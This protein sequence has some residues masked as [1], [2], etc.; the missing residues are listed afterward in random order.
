MSLVHVIKQDA[1]DTATIRRKLEDCGVVACSRGDRVLLKPNM[2]GA[3]RPEKAVTTHPAVVEAVAGI[4]VDSGAEVILGDSPGAVSME[5]AMA[6]CGYEPLVKHMGLQTL[7][8]SRTVTVAGTHFRDIRLA[9]QAL[10]CDCIVNLPKVKTHGQML[11]TLALKNL[12]GLV[13]GLGKAHWHLRTGGDQA[14]FA[15][16]LADIAHTVLSRVRSV[17]VADGV[18]SMEGRGPSSGRPRQ[19]S[20]LAVSGSALALDTAVCSLLGFP[21]G[22]LPVLEPAGRLFPEEEHSVELRF[23]GFDREPTLPVVGN[24]RFIE[25]ESLGRPLLFPPFLWR[26][27]RSWWVPM[28]KVARDK[29]VSCRQCARICAA[30]AISFAGEVPYP[31]FDQAKC[32]RCYCCEEICPENAITVVRPLFRRL[33]QPGRPKSVP[34]ADE[35]NAGENGQA[36]Q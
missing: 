13:P 24:F 2:L 25:V 28:P 17:H 35:N 30:E 12:F 23:A 7:D 34:R 26:L 32:I 22:D 4:C 10:E 14:Q 18:V 29:C 15:R 16:L 27:L 20:F 5:K 3:F 8:L 33:F 6:A 21:A 31:V 36:Q 1:Y 19:T 11:L 9:A